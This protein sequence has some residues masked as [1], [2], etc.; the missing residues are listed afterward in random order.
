M[1]LGFCVDIQLF[2]RSLSPRSNG[3]ETALRIPEC[4]FSFIEQKA[5]SP[6]K[7]ETST[8]LFP[9]P[10]FP[11]KPACIKLSETSVS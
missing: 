4:F 2:I 11:P 9:L 3:G 6:L 7:Y 5:L 1:L 10:V 8:H